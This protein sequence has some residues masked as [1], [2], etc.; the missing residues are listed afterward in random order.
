MATPGNDDDALRDE[1]RELLLRLDG[2]AALKYRQSANGCGFWFL[3]GASIDERAPWELM[4]KRLISGGAP[5]SDAPL[6]LTERGRALA[7]RLRAG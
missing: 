1:A 6:A 5:G 3:D 4:G 7:A 2:G